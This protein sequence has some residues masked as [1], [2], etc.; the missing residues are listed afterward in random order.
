VHATAGGDKLEEA[1]RTH[2]N[3]ETDEFKSNRQHPD[4]LM[5]RGFFRFGT[6]PEASLKGTEFRLTKPFRPTN[7]TIFNSI[8]YVSGG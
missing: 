3:K 7:H 8:L 1:T 5:K 6:L 4:L 2:S